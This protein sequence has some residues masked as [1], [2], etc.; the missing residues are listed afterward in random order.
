M[1]ITI[2]DVYG[3]VMGA[4]D[5][6]FPSVPHQGEDAEP[7]A[8]GE[9]FLI[10]L[11]P[12]EQARAIG[13]RRLRSYRF[14]IQYIAPA[15]SGYEAIFDVIELLFECMEQI[16]VGGH[17][18]RG[19]DMRYEFTEGKMHFYVTYQLH[20]RVESASLPSMQRMDQEVSVI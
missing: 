3:G 7:Q 12:V 16:E 2:N 19:S 1:D 9:R 14:D 15:G 4:L 5:E 17:S 6:R 18:I 20:M 10:T 11:S 8:D 13:P